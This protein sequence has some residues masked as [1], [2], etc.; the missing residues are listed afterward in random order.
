[1]DK[2][3]V[4]IEETISF[5][6]FLNDVEVR[7]PLKK[8]QIYSILRNT[9]LLHDVSKRRNF[10]RNVFYLP[11]NFNCVG[12]IFC[13]HVIFGYTQTIVSTYILLKLFYDLIKLTDYPT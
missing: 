3:Y 4:K 12:E 11:S 9:I 2:S 7:I 1:L 6:D 5:V 13:G 10:S 8:I